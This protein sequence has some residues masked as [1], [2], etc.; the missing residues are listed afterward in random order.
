MAAAMKG[1]AEAAVVAAMDRKAAQTGQAGEAGVARS[2][3]W[4]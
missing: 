4:A 3:K 2:N 1:S